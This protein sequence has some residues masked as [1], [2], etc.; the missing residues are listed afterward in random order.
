[1]YDPKR[2][3][4]VLAAPLTRLHG[5]IGRAF[6]SGQPAPP[7]FIVHQ[8]LV[9]PEFT[10]STQ[11]AKLHPMSRN[12]VNVMNDSAGQVQASPEAQ[13]EQKEI[14]AMANG[15]R[16]EQSS[17]LSL[18]DQLLNSTSE[19]TG[20]TSSPPAPVTNTMLSANATT[21]A[22][23]SALFDLSSTSASAQSTNVQQS[24]TLFDIFST[25]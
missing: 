23:L 8:L 11:F 21:D 7:L 24:T 15:S 25:K 16:V 4:E 22:T 20:S 10:Y 9:S 5:R 2:L 12:G 14:R 3:A 1:M 17:S 19:P 18:L 13:P 6:H